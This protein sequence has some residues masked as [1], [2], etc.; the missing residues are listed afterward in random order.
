MVPALP[1]R[2]MKMPETLVPRRSA[3]YEAGAAFF[4]RK[5]RIW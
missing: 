2:R 5:L 1:R 3:T 4:P